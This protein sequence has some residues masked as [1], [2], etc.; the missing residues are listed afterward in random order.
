MATSNAQQ[1]LTSGS[2]PR[3][4]GLKMF[5]G[6]VI[7][8]YR[9]E[10]ILWNAIDGGG[11]NV[12]ASK[13][14]TEGVSWQFPIIGDDPTPE[15]H[16]PGVELLGMDVSL[17]EGTITIDDILVSH[18]DVPLDQTELSHFDVIAPFARKLGRSLAIDFDKKMI[19]LGVLTS[20]PSNSTPGV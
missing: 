18:Y 17:D 4:L 3:G 12:I 6:R 15:Y 2:D 8:A 14:I 11:P 20:M 16:T 1:F 10:T 13:M 9:A 5:W 7:E 19:Q